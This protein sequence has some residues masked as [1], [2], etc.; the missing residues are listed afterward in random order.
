MRICF[1]WEEPL[2]FVVSLLILQ[3]VDYPC[4][5]S[6][7]I[8][9]AL[10]KKWIWQ[11]LVP[12]QIQPINCMGLSI[13]WDVIKPSTM[14]SRLL[15]SQHA[16]TIFSLQIRKLFDVYE[17]S[18]HIYVSTYHACLVPTEAKGW[19]QITLD[20]SHRQLWTAM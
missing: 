3:D 8:L 15:M 13:T 1:L 14:R 6:M 9:F 4:R 16:S 19:H 5:T 20:W 17:C 18:V 2:I 12:I 7:N 10:K 11:L